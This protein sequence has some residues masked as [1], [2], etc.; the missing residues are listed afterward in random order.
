MTFEILDIAEGLLLLDPV[1]TFPQR[2]AAL[3]AKL[4]GAPTH[5]LDL[6]DGDICH[7]SEPPPARGAAAVAL[8]LRD[9]RNMLGTLVLEVPDGRERLFDEELRLARWGSRVLARG[10]GYSKRLSVV[11]TRRSGEE[12]QRFLERSALTPRECDVVG[13]L[14]SG[15]S[16]RE[17]A[18]RTGLTTATVNTYL[19]RIFSKLGVHS[20]VELVAR[21][22]GTDGIDPGPVRSKT[23]PPDARA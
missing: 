23:E 16:T 10:L 20:R 15:G 6:I 3:V 22:A 1:R 4:V 5:K 17:I 7:Q 19:K 8:P 13:L 14:T 11:H 2:G 9:G 21:L 12:L 18:E